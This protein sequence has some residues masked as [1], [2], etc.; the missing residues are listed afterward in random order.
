V[1]KVLLAGSALVC[2]TLVA[3]SAAEAS[4]ATYISVPPPPGATTQYI[5]WSINDNNIVAGAYV[6]SD[7]LQHGF[8]GPLD[9]SNYTTF[10][11]AGKGTT[12]TQ[13]RFIFNNGKINGIGLGGAFAFGEE[14]VRNAKG[15]IHPIKNGKQLLD[16]VVQGGNDADEFV[17]DYLNS[18]GIRIGYLG[19][20][21]KYKSDIKLKLK[22]LISTDP[23]QI[24][25]NGV[26]AGGY[27]DSTGIQH[28]F[29]LD[30]KKLTSFD[31]P[32]AVNVTVAE[33][34]NDSGVAVGLWQDSG[35]NRHGFTYDSTT[36]T[37]TLITGPNDG[38]TAQETWGINNAGLVSGDSNGASWIY[39]PLPK[40]RCPAGGRAIEVDVHSIHVA[41]GKLM[42]GKSFKPM[43]N[44][45]QGP[46]L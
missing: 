30:G 3:S 29:V 9:G 2:A 28:G 27:V 12:G 5:T 18:S 41:P 33:G 17:G 10:D 1:K 20:R 43:H 39:C 34:I 15:R 11:F 42:N 32:D 13:P 4:K 16:G 19:A 38:S 23:R 36:G 14:F 37:F 26:I 31:Y 25:D 35:S 24:N 7:G 45:K 22:H 21:G 46:R 6:G 44:P 8:F 40:K